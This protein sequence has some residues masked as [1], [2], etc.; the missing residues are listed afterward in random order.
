LP[1]YARHFVFFFSFALPPLLIIASFAIVF[2]FSPF[3]F[4]DTIAAFSYDIYCSLPIL[5]ISLM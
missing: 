3:S 1:G 5:T 4:S 2:F